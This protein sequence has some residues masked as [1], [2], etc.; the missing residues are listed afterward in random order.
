MRKLAGILFF[1]ALVALVLMMMAPSA[2]EGVLRDVGQALRSFW[3][4]PVTG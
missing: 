3:G 4:Y 1:V 2:P